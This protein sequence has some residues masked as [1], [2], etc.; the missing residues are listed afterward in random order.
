MKPYERLIA[1]NILCDTLQFQC[2]FDEYICDG[3]MGRMKE[4]SEFTVKGINTDTMVE[5]GAR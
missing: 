1:K 3:E 4:E 5:T 2:P